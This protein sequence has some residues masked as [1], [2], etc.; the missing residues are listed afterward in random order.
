MSRAIFWLG[1]AVRALN[2]CLC[3]GVVVFGTTSLHSQSSD[4]VQRNSNTMD[5]AL[6]SFPDPTTRIPNAATFEFPDGKHQ[7]RNYLNTTFGPAAFVRAAIGAGLD[8][9]KPA[10]PE[11]DTGVEGYGQRYGFRFGMNLITETTRYSAGALMGQDVAY[12]K[13][14]CAGLLPRTSHALISPF[15]AKSK[16][17]NTI[18]SLPSIAAPFAGSFAAVNAW[19]PARYEPMDAA[20]LGGFSFALSMG[21]NLVRE[22][23]LP[24]R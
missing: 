23:L 20:R 16:S 15:T 24:G 10:P 4:Q 1:S 11:W 8:Q 12:H 2:K 17:G 6:P 5:S 18:V 3:I 9:S 21:A 14:M 19:Y 22:F 13:C 7:F